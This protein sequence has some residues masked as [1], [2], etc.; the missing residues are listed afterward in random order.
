MKVNS[1]GVLILWGLLATVPLQSQAA[2]PSDPGSAP[3]PTKFATAPLRLRVSPTLAMLEAPGAVLRTPGIV[4]Q[5][6]P[7]PPGAVAMVAKENQ[8]HGLETVSAW[9]QARLDWIAEML[10]RTLEVPPEDRFVQ[11][12]LATVFPEP[13]SVRVGKVWLGGGIVN[14]VH[15]DNPFAL[16]NFDVF[17]VS[18]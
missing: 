4:Q 17:H 8:K 12:A 13:V 18:F 2:V 9:E 7:P 11:G 6:S 3:K 5:V 15:R 10:P 1:L 14:A 16:L